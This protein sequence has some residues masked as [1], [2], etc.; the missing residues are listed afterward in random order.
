MNGPPDPECAGLTEP[1]EMCPE[2]ADTE[3]SAFGTVPEP[4]TAWLLAAG[5]A[6]LLAAGR[7]RS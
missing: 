2:A 4:L 1:T 7:K 5:L 3:D 6:G